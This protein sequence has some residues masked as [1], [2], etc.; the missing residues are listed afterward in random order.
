MKDYPT[1]TRGRY[2]WVYVVIVFKNISITYIDIDTGIC[3]C[4]LNLD[5]KEISM[6]IVNF[7]RAVLFLLNLKL[8]YTVVEIKGFAGGNYY[9]QH[10]LNSQVWM[11]VD[12]DA[13]WGHTAIAGQ[14]KE[15]MY[16]ILR[17]SNIA[18]DCND[19]EGH[20]IW[21]SALSRFGSR[22]VY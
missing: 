12:K 1:G 10:K 9:L 14:Y 4:V 13:V 22:A 6:Y 16:D 2:L 17:K 19:M 21:T 8:F 7:I 15:I 20:W 3:A 18:R 5:L 11:A